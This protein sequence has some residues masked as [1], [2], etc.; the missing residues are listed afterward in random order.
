MNTILLTILANILHCSTLIFRQHLW[1]LASH[2]TH[3]RAS[4]LITSSEH[5]GHF[6]A[7]DSDFDGET[8]GLRC[9][10]ICFAGNILFTGIDSRGH[11]FAPYCRHLKRK[12]TKQKQFQV[13][14]T[15]SFKVPFKQATVPQLDGFSEE[16]FFRLECENPVSLAKSRPVHVCSSPGY[17]TVKKRYG[18]ILFGTLQRRIRVF[19]SVWGREVEVSNHFELMHVYHMFTNQTCIASWLNL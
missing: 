13:R 2:Q 19:Q 10:F 8:E 5:I 4:S 1:W 3:C 9:R 12:Q 15:L 16:V 18:A 11:Y 6:P 17:S 14:K 7:S